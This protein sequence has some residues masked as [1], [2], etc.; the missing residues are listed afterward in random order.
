MKWTTTKVVGKML[1]N[2]ASKVASTSEY[3]AIFVLALLFTWHEIITTLELFNASCI[4]MNAF[5][6]SS[7][8]VTL[9]HCEKSKGMRGIFEYSLIV[10]TS[11]TS[12]SAYRSAFG[13]SDGF[14]SNF[15]VESIIRYNTNRK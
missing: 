7:A 3:D 14:L 1:Q 4:C 11:T 8:G 12:T 10:H 5:I 6:P 2:G 9:C 13:Q 15:H